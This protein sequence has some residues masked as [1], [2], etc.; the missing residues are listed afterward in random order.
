ML[1]HTLLKQRAPCLASEEGGSS[2]AGAGGTAAFPQFRTRAD[3][4]GTRGRT[5]QGQGASHWAVTGALAVG[6][7]SPR[8]GPAPALGSVRLASQLRVSVRVRVHRQRGLGV[9][10]TQG[11][12]F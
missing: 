3:A 11:P 4:G 2:G 12:A 6:L 1:T 5:R 10:F 8:W 9:W 7:R